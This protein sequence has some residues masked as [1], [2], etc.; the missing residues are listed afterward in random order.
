[1]SSKQFRQLYSDAKTV[2]TVTFARFSEANYKNYT[3]GGFH[4]Q[5]YCDSTYITRMS[6]SVAAAEHHLVH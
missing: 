5:V 1:M 6:G 3:N 4:Y 2:F